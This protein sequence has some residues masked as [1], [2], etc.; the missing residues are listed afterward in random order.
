VPHL[1]LVAETRC[2]VS[3]WQ[4]TRE[5]PGPAFTAAPFIW[6]ASGPTS[7]PGGLIFIVLE[8]FHGSRGLNAS[9]PWRKPKTKSV[10]P[11]LKH[12]SRNRVA[13]VRTGQG[14]WGVPLTCPSLGVAQGGC[15]TLGGPAFEP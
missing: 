4:V 11:G 13:F 9:S 8:M 5:R 2:S 7:F 10:P 15:R 6:S 3:C 14:R 1:A 12:K